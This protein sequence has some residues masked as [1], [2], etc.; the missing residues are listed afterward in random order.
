M[1]CTRATTMASDG[2]AD[3]STLRQR[4]GHKAGTDEPAVAADHTSSPPERKVPQGAA[5]QLSGVVA[6]LD[7]IPEW[8][9]V[10]AILTALAFATRF[11]RL[12][13]PPAV[14]FDE[15]HFGRFTNQYWKGEYFFDIHPPLGTCGSVLRLLR[16]PLPPACLEHTLALS[17][18]TR[19]ACPAAAVPCVPCACRAELQAAVAPHPSRKL[20]RS[21]QASGV[22]C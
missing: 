10:P 17:E 2:E 11:W 18:A 14:V 8:P 7:E 3:S 5:Q 13:E 12:D 19:V 9:W 20:H 1:Q 15:H 16:C 22:S 4:R 6:A 21:S